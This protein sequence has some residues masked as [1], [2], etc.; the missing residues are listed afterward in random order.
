M[1]ESQG[2]ADTG[3]MHGLV[4]AGRPTGAL[5]D[6]QSVVRFAYENF[7]S[8]DLLEVAF[9]TQIGVALRQELGIDRAVW[10]MT[11][12][13]TLVQSLVLEHE[14]PALRLMAAKTAFVHG[15]HR[16]ASA[17]VDRTFV[18]RMAIGA[19]QFVLRHGMVVGQTKLAAHVGVTLE[20]NRFRRARRTERNPRPEAV[21]C[22]ASR[23][24]AIGGQNVSTGIGVKAARAV[25]GF[26]AS[27]HH[28]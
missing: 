3:T 13:A 25:A 17:N 1:L 18:R 26:A 11:D 2:G 22:R 7:A 4:A 24:E 23:R 9:Q 12:G 14:W 5:L 8:A 20:A 28:I 19:T 6:T 10:R 16:S 15:E 21:K 27:V